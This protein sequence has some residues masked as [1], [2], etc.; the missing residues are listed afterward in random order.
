M[1]S[2]RCILHTYYAYCDDL[3]EEAGLFYSNTF[4][5]TADN[6]VE[7]DKKSPPKYQVFE[8]IGLG[9]KFVLWI[10]P[11]VNSK[12]NILLALKKWK[13]AWKNL[14]DFVV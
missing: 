8:N 5:Q 12:Q 7:K 13:K 10:C 14:Q 4:L 6:A 2:V 9:L 3:S 11:F 1:A